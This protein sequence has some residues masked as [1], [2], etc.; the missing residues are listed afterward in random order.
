MDSYP[1]YEN[2]CRNRSEKITT[3]TT[4][5]LDRHQN[6]NYYTIFFCLK[7]SQKIFYLSIFPSNKMLRKTK[8]AFPTAF[9]NQILKKFIH[10]C[11]EK[12]ISK[13]IIFAIPVRQWNGGISKWKIHCIIL[14]QHSLNCLA[15][16]GDVKF[17]PHVS[18]VIGSFQ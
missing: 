11:F 9:F 12:E 14:T 7:R 10:N 3:P 8:K 16:M 1:H 6:T 5:N 4:T 15:S 17:K 2:I 13:I 18:F